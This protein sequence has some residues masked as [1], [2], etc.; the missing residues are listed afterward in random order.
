MRRALPVVFVAVFTACSSKETKS[1]TT[2]G[3]VGEE[4][5]TTTA[6]SDRPPQPPPARKK[7]RGT[8]GTIEVDG[9]FRPGASMIPL[10]AGM[11]ADVEYVRYSDG[12]SALGRLVIVHREEPGLAATPEPKLE[13]A[14][15]DALSSVA[16]PGGTMDTGLILLPDGQDARIL[17]TRSQLG[18]GIVAT[19]RKKLRVYELICVDDSD[20]IACLDI[21]KTFA[22]GAP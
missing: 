12:G 3:D 17:C 19:A 18:P 15:G 4:V 16:C 10:P 14:T 11:T 7:L 6:S 1:G 13:H 22:P 8:W 2:S 9:A 20:P 5:E 21:L